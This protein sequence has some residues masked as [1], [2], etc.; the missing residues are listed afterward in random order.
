MHVADLEVLMDLLARPELCSEAMRVFERAVTWGLVSDLEV[1]FP[2]TLL[3]LASNDI[4]SM[5]K[6]HSMFTDLPH[7]ASKKRA[8]P[9]AGGSG[10]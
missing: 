1:G 9:N 7:T 6:L 4:R 3:H 5:I 8:L 2:P 10:S